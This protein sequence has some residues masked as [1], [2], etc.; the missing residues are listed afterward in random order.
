VS[1]SPKSPKTPVT[2][3]C[4]AIGR[5]CCCGRRGIPACWRPLRSRT[6]YP[7][8]CAASRAWERT[9]SARRVSSITRCRSSRLSTPTACPTAG[10]LRRRRSMI[11]RPASCFWRSACRAPS[12]APTRTRWDTTSKWRRLRQAWAATRQTRLSG[13]LMS[14]YGISTWSSMTTRQPARRSSR[15]VREK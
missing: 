3:R 10:P 2:S 15:Y 5:I 14:P 6:S 4:S 12:A 1:Y 8:A 11:L 9:R 13:T 7:G